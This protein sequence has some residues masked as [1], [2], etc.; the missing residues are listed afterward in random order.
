MLQLRNCL[1]SDGICVG[2]WAV[3]DELTVEPQTPRPGGG[4]LF[5]GNDVH[6]EKEGYGPLAADLRGKAMALENRIVLVRA[7]SG[8]LQL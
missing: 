4:P 3:L 8:E 5:A 1:A 2:A 7:G 6:G